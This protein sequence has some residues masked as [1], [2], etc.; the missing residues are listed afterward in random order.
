LQSNLPAVIEYAESHG[1]EIPVSEDA[2][3]DDGEPENSAEFDAGSLAAALLG[4][5]SS[6]DSS[7][8]TAKM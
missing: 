8:H 6:S 4:A 2:I 3:S 1:I 7:T 5:A